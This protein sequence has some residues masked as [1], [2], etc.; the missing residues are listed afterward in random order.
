M[1]RSAREPKVG[2]VGL[3]HPDGRTGEPIPK[4]LGAVRMELDGDDARAGRNQSRRERASAR[5][6]VDDEVTGLDGGLLDE[7]LRPVVSEL[8]P[9]P[10]CPLVRGHDA[11]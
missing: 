7:Q 3:H 2:G 10:A 6:D 8:V 5:A 4:L 1:E 11:P 9:A